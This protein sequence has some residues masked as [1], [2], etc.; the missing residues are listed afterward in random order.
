[1]LDNHDDSIVVN[2]VEY[3]RKSDTTKCVKQH[4]GNL[5]IVVL[6][7]RWIYIGYLDRIDNHCRLHNAYNI[8]VWGTK[9]GLG[10]LVHGATSDTVLDKCDGTVEFD[11]SM[12]VHTI[13]VDA[14]QWK[15]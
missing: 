7:Q 5:K 8:R 10:E 3:I 11:W 4:V 1:M 9:N 14:S 15:L 6:Q 2:G 13:E 12:V